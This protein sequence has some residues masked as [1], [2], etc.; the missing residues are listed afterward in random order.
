MN[1][2]HF[3]NLSTNLRAEHLAGMG[4]LIVQIKDVTIRGLSQTF[5]EQPSGSLV[6]LINSEGFLEIAEV[7]GSAARHLNAVT[8]DLVE[9]IPV[10]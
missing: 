8:Y 7:N 6:A 5:G 10:N 1:I 9:V 2:D 4:D 3:G